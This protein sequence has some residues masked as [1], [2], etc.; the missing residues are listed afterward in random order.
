MD[1]LE[2]FDERLSERTL[3]SYLLVRDQLLKDFWNMSDDFTNYAYI[4]KYY[5]KSD[6]KF[7][8]WVNSIFSLYQ[9]IRPQILEEV[10]KNAISK[11]KKAMDIM[12]KYI[13]GLPNST[14]IFEDAKIVTLSL[15]EFLYDLDLTKV[16]KMR[17]NPK[18]LM[19]SP[20]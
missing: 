6:I 19:E 4:Y 2:I 16:T 13:I 18:T 8:K 14:L 20:G 12:E 15:G 17:I 11:Y 3:P 9:D 10:K 5:G 7:S 1:R